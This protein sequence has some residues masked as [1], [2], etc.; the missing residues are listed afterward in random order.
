ME[1]FANNLREYTIS[2]LNGNQIN[3][4]YDFFVSKFIYYMD[5]YCA[6]LKKTH[7]DILNNDKM[8]ESVFLLFNNVVIKKQLNLELV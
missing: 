4:E 1:N 5:A 3:N 7:G 2:H 8:Y 6:E